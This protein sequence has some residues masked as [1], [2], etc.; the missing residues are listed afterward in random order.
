M[1]HG[2]A[3][4][5][6]HTYDLL[7]DAFEADNARTREDFDCTIESF[8]DHYDINIEPKD[9]SLLILR[10]SERGMIDHAFEL[11]EAAKKI[12]PKDSGIYT[13]RASIHAKLGEPLEAAKYVAKAI[14]AN[15]NDFFAYNFGSKLAAAGNEHAVA[16][17][18]ALK[19]AEL[20]APPFK[21]DRQFKQHKIRYKNNFNKRTCSKF[22]SFNKSKRKKR[23]RKKLRQKRK[24]S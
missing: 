24:T 15:P 19:S 20:T 5:G 23:E 7:F 17:Q 12:F 14:E 22:E 2:R 11:F 4:S 3:R 16:K 10:F 1:L 9:L 18:L 6:V 8:E 13:E 21:N